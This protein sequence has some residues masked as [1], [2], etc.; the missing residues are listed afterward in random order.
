MSGPVRTLL[1][2]QGPPSHFWREL[3]ASFEAA[4][5]RVIKVN[6]STAERLYWGR[7]DAIS[8]RGRLQDWGDWLA[9]RIRCEGVTDVVYY[10]DQQPYHRIAAHVA[11]ELGATPY[12]IEFGYLRPAW[13]T[14]ERGGMG[15][16]SHFPNDPAGIRA[17]AAQVDNVPEERVFPYSFAQEAFNE[18]FY[19]LVNYFYFYFFPHYQADRFYNPVLEYVSAPLRWFRQWRRSRKHAAALAASMARPFV[20]IPLQLQ[21]D[22]QIRYNSPYS[23][24][25]QM[26][27]EVFASFAR[28][29]PPELGIVVKQHPLDVGLIDWCPEVMKLAREAG[30]ADRV[31][32]IDGGVLSEMLERAES[33][34]VINSTVGLHALRV[35]RPTKVMGVALYDI[36][37][38]TSDAPLDRFWSDPGRVD[39]DLLD[40]LVRGL[41]GTIQLPGS[42]YNPE[43]SAHARAIIV[44]RILAGTVNGAG[45]F[46]DP[47]PR[48][49]AT[50]AANARRRERLRQNS[51]ERSRLEGGRR[52]DRRVAAG[53]T[54]SSDDSARS[55]R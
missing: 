12:V 23:D 47:P 34:V 19:H 4:G 51:P 11:P 53:A 7:H 16:W 1:F 40:A 2:L 41:A 55:P 50:H 36:E 29:A 30:I 42:F 52:A 15:G 24:Q 21:N 32:A 6:F 46:V 48:L 35:G 49:G 43:G 10:G 3:A 5:H 33:V 13:I 8:Y 39:M 27:R 37:G 38:L 18:V 17:I 31:T 20:L 22:Y 9:E 28:H 26:L 54:A 14:L 25:R 44:E 45:A